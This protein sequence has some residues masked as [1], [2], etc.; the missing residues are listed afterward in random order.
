MLCITNQELGWQI[1][2]TVAVQP[3]DWRLIVQRVPRQYNVLSTRGM[4]GR[5]RVGC[6]EIAYN[7]GESGLGGKRLIR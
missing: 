3:G 6:Y 4:I 1:C 2:P 5:A 7:S